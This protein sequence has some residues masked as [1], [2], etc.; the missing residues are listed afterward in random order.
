MVGLVAE[1]VGVD[2]S[3]ASMLEPAAALVLAASGSRVVLPIVCLGNLD[4]ICLG[5]LLA[6]FMV[7]V[8]AVLGDL[9]IRVLWN[10][11]P[12]RGRGPRVS[13]PLA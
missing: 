11:G 12:I 5:W 8:A 1:V 7:G 3:V 2:A 10:P 9:S 4:I 6:F 13:A